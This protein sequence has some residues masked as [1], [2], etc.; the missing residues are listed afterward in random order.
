[1]AH[2]IRTTHVGS[3]PRPDELLEANARRSGGAI[4]D[5]EFASVLGASVEQVVARQREIG[6]DIV[7]E[8]EYGHITSGAVDYGA[9]WNYSFT[10]L[11]GLTMTDEDRW[12]NPEIVRSTP[13]NPRLTSF[14]DR[15]DRAAFRAAY[16]DPDSGILTG[17]ASVGNPKITGPLTYIGSEAVGADIELL[18]EGLADNGLSP[19]DGFI[20]ALSPGS[21]ARVRNEYYDSDAD[22]LAACADAMHEEYKAITDAGLTVQIDAPDLAESWD[23]INP[24]PTVS[25]Y[26]D[27]IG[28]R[29]DAINR[30]LESIPAD[31]VRLH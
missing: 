4:D 19:A 5:E 7:N 2:R 22:L 11:G 8:G 30:A 17:R 25:D 1:M 26:R 20:A 21:A 28:L 24:E 23:Q 13:G 16:E 18:L 10:R 29:I 31:Q 3:L 9:W 15:R 6:L 14:P 27:F 12:A